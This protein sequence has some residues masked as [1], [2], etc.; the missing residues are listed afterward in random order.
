MIFFFVFF[1]R[2]FSHFIL[3]VDIIYTVCERLGK[4][5]QKK[6]TKTI[7]TFCLNFLTKLNKLL[8]LTLNLTN[9]FYTPYINI[10]FLCLKGYSFCLFY[11][12]FFF[13]FKNET[14][15]FHCV[16]NVFLRIFIIFFVVITSNLLLRHV[17]NIIIFNDFCLRYAF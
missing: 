5:V 4:R 15:E 13:T 17:I 8:Y 16:Q 12:I 14:V 1:K 6:K 11:L 2:H 3:S 7:I 10:Y 9:Y